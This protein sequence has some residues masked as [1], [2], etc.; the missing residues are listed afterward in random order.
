MEGRVVLDEVL[1]RFPEWEVAVDGARL[2]SS[3]VR[4]WATLPV[5]VG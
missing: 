5:A 4:G 1:T 3:I 2:D